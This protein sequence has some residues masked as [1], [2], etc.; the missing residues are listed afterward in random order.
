MKKFIFTILALLMILSFPIDHGLAWGPAT[1]TYIVRKL[2]KRPGLVNAQKMYGS[3]APDIFSYIYRVPD[4][5]FLNQQMHHEF[6]GVLTAAAAT[7]QKNLKAFALGFI[8][9]NDVWG[10][11]YLARNEQGYITLKAD[12]LIYK[13][14]KGN[15][16]QFSE[17]LKGTLRALI[18][19][20]Y[21]EARD[22]GCIAVEYGV[23]LLVRRYSDPEIGAR[24]ILA[25][26]LRDHEIPHLLASVYGYKEEAA[27]TI[28]EAEAAFKKIMADY[29]KD[30]LMDERS[31]IEAVAEQIAEI[32]PKALCIDLPEK[33]KLIRIGIELISGAMNVCRTDY[34]QSI[35]ATVEAIRKNIEKVNADL[36]LP[37][38]FE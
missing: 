13:V 15:P 25:T 21:Q 29:G 19:L 26:T 8:S 30:L 37:D 2:D 22:L 6:M 20:D 1:H 14:L 38:N 12:Q 11:D 7:D 23:D 10:A 5:K 3:I 24:L 33:D 34:S 18:A 9:H 27:K 4:R 16:E 28:I 36:D 35:S 31:A 17:E 32:A